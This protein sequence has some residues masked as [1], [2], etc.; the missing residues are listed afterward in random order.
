MRPSFTKHLKL[1]A[2]LK[3]L[4][5]AS[6]ALCLAQSSRVWSPLAAQDPLTP[7]E[8]RGR[9]IYRLGTSSSGN[10]ILAYV[11]ESSLEVPGSAL[12]CANCH[13][14]D[15]HG[16]PEAG[17]NPSGLSW[18]TLT[19][20]YAVTRA[21]GRQRPPYTERA[22]ELTIT[23]GID[24]AGNKLLNVMPRY[25][26]SRDD[27]A[28]LVVYLKR[29]GTDRD[30]GITENKIVIGTA[31]PSTGA[32]AE[33]GKAVKAVIT[34][35]FENINSQGGIYNRRLEL[36]SIETAQTPAATRANLE[37]FLKDEDVFAMTSTFVVG[38]E[39]ET[40]P[41]MAQKEVPLIGPVT[42]YPQTGLP[43]N[44]QVFYL[45]SGIDEQARVLIDFAARKAENKTTRFGIV[46]TQTEANGRALE[47]I[48]EQAKK[49]GLITPEDYDYPAGRFDSADA[50]RKLRESNRDVVFL[51][52]AGEDAL[53][54]MK[55]AEKLNWFPS[56]YLPGG[57]VGREIL[58]AP[59]GFNGKLFFAFPTSPADQTSE[60][61]QEFRALAEK[62]KLPAQHL[63]AQISAYSAAKIL[64]E[65]LKRAGKDVSREKLIVTLEGFNGFE[66]GLTPAISYGPNRRIGA[67]GAYVVSVDLEK[68]Q[69]VPASAWISIN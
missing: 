33:M 22:L 9:H 42:L 29:L 41:L 27:L 43:L 30:P 12:P 16:K 63:A 64:V 40:I 21:N 66:T 10:E 56:I 50:V 32:L 28:D 15:G 55:E 48:R 5:L 62:Y 59:A 35:F 24:P 61:I 38:S 14:F 36:K 8:I 26:M 54:F 44:R 51:L 7:Q 1:F 34:A 49:D 57:S 52:G 2:G 18:D 47:T 20:P 3:Y 45:L 65:A 37:R 19:K 11:G 53:S 13:G 17:V 25:Q 23:R 46:H 60:G 69:F 58:N 39:K 68:K 6:L 31:V 4:A 67:L